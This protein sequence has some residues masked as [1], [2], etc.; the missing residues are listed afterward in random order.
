M[1]AHVFLVETIAFAPYRTHRLIFLEPSPSAHGAFFEVVGS[2]KEGMSF[3]QTKFQK[4]PEDLTAYLKK[5]LL[6]QV[7]GV[8]RKEFAAIMRSIQPPVAQEHFPNIDKSRP[9]RLCHEWA[10]EAIQAALRAGVLH[11]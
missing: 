10:E 8:Y 1:A 11:P 6:G 4:K 3:C 9:F 7:Q 2:A 5:S